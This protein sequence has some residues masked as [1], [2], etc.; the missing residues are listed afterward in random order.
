MSSRGVVTCGRDA[1][2]GR[3]G[4]VVWTVT[5]VDSVVVVVV[6]VVVAS[7]GDMV[8]QLYGRNAPSKSSK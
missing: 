3:W 8:P 2:G 7:S 4:P 6:V 5:H 1:L